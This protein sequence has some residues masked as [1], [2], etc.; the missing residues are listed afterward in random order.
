MT[1]CHGRR[2]MYA[3]TTTRV[4]LAMSGLICDL[5]RT[6]NEA[7]TPS[8]GIAEQ[9]TPSSTAKAPGADIGYP[10]ITSGGRIHELGHG[11]KCVSLRAL[12]RGAPRRTNRN[13]MR[14]LRVGRVLFARREFVR[15]VLHRRECR[16]FLRGTGAQ[17]ETNMAGQARPRELQTTETRVSRTSSIPTPRRRSGRSL[18]RSAAR[19]TDAG[20]CWLCGSPRSA[21]SSR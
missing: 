19:S 3:G 14:G 11:L 9:N 18:R 5:L 4:E 8:T 21:G 1:L 7:P 20:C 13:Q 12:P 15:A 2:M 6:R 17:A 16:P 10:R